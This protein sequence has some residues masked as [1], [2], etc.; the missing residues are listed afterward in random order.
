MNFKE[1][2]KQDNVNTFMNNEEF[3]N[4]II[5]NGAEVCAVEDND[6]LLYRIQ[7]NYSGLVVGDILFYITAAEW[8]KIPRVSARP[9]VNIAIVYD[10]KPSTV[11]NVSEQDG[12]YEIILQHS[13]GGY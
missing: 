1:Y 11:T 12:I 3:A 10:G 7:Q 9:T 8:A 6:K 4:G 2:V 5:I 13:G